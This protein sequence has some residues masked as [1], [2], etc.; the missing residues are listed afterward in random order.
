MRVDGTVDTLTS[1][2]LDTVL[3]TLVRHGRCRLVIDLAG[4]RYVSSA[5]WGVFVS[6]LR[7]AREGGG[8]LK[9]ARM[10][11]PV[12]EIYDL[13]EFEGV[14]HH[15]E[16]LD[17]AIAQF[18]GGNGRGANGGSATARPEH[19]PGEGEPVSQPPRAARPSRE[20]AILQLV[21]EDPFYTIRELQA[22]L[23]AA[24]HPRVNRW[25]IRRVL[26]RHRLLLRRQRLEYYRREAT[27]H[28][29]GG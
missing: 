28:D 24:G 14:L 19:G 21:R 3:G 8:D 27:S 4:V 11:P 13:L 16:R 25:V 29:T 15:F 23:L 9:L 22:N 26:W 17:G 7:E 18:G 20:A 10:T 2:D 6:R 5:G 12:R 1:G